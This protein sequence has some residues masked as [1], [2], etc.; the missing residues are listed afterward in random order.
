[1]LH[2]RGNCARRKL[3]TSEMMRA[4]IYVKNQIIDSPLENVGF[5]F[6][7]YAQIDFVSEIILLAFNTFEY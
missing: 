7:D 1:M 3:E 6:L 4:S 2:H 5:F